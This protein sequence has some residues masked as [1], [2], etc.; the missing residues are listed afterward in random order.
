MMIICVTRAAID[1][2]P[3][4]T[5]VRRAIRFSS[6]STRMTPAADGRGGG[7]GARGLGR[8]LL[9]LGRGLMDL[10]DD[11]VPLAG[12]LVERGAHLLRGARDVLEDGDRVVAE[13][14]DP[15]DDEARER[16]EGQCR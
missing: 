9:D 2:P 13:C 14:V 3:H 7:R 1:D 4:H 11:A 12:T 8:S 10:L 15:V 6:T 16:E 5:Y